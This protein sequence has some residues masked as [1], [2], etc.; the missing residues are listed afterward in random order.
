[1][2]TLT[3]TPRA[4]Q[5]VT[6]ASS[7]QLLR[8]FAAIDSDSSDNDEAS[9]SARKSISTRCRSQKKRK[10]MMKKE[11]STSIENNSSSASASFKVVERKSLLPQYYQRGNNSTSRRTSS[12]GA[13]LLKKIG[14]SKSHPSYARVARDFRTK[15]LLSAIEKTWSKT[16]R[17]ASKIF[18]EKHYNR[19]RILI[20]D[21]V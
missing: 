20:D 13:S 18:M 16:V 3:P 6:K 10:V 7:D 8:K 5:H 21:M 9:S 17:G 15:S 1:M 19:H 11:M 4:I 14:I 2:E 12:S